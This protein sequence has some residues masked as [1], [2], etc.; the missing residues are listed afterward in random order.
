MPDLQWTLCRCGHRHPAWVGRCPRC[1]AYRVRYVDLT[2][3]FPHP[4]MG[5]SDVVA[6]ELS[7]EQRRATGRTLG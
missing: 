7:P 6:T 1:G 4:V 2:G 3:L 5:I